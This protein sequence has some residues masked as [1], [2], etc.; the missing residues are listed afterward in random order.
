MDQ[1]RPLVT[2]TGEPKLLTVAQQELYLHVLTLG[3]SP[4]SACGKIGI[5][6]VDVLK[7]IDLDE[8]FR[9][10]V[11]RVNL[12]L[13]QNVAAALY[14]SAMEGSVSAQTFFLKNKPPPDWQAEED[15]ELTREYLEELSDEEFVD[16]C[17]ASGLEPPIETP[18]GT[19]SQAVEE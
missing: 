4:T 16:L 19:D 9:E 17:R 14:R 13:S 3:A 15:T 18:P 6:A 5:T 2:T 11:D 10:Q 7:T 12:L 1:R 8:T